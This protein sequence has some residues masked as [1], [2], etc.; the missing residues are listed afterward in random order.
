MIRKKSVLG[1]DPGMDIGFPKR[2][3]SSAYEAARHRVERLDPGLGDE[4][5]LASLH[6]SLAVARDDVGL[7]DDD[8]S[9]AE[10]LIGHMRARAAFRA[11]YRRQIGA[12]IAVQQIVDDGRA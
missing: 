9:G 3:F 7:D 6:T 12:A 5:H 2:S 1:R 10:R 8:H 4:H 11:E